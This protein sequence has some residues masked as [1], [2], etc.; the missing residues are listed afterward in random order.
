MKLT[1]HFKSA[2]NVCMSI[3]SFPNMLSIGVWYDTNF[4]LSVLLK[5]CRTVPPSTPKITCYNH[6]A[7]SHTKIS[8]LYVWSTQ[9]FKQV[10][11]SIGFEN[12][13]SKNLPYFNML[14]WEVLRYENCRGFDWSGCSSDF[15]SDTNWRKRNFFGQDISMMSS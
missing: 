7:L 9:Y 12:R 13:L 14:F 5:F 11:R 8:V 1:W 4:Q 3:D 15:R 10:T 2:V 6:N